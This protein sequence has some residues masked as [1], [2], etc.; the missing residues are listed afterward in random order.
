MIQE[1]GI[2]FVESFKGKNAYVHLT[3]IFVTYIFVVFGIDWQYF[4]FMNAHA[5]RYMLFSADII[6]LL[7]PIFFP[8]GLV[9]FGR[10]KQNILYVKTGWILAKTV[11]VSFSIALLYKSIVGR[12]SPPH[13]GELIVDTSNQFNFGFLQHSILGGWP[14]SHAT[15]MFAIA[16]ALVTLFPRSLCI[17]IGVYALA[18]Y[19]GL[20][21]AIGFHFISDFIA[22]ALIGT[23]VGRTVVQKSVHQK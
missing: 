9:V 4:L 6:G 17:R 2:L 8:V 12:A 11:I 10:W 3:A 14:S 15:V 19:I 5:P 21:V 16:I 7:F 13:H 23:V 1:L 18:V 22:G 20:G